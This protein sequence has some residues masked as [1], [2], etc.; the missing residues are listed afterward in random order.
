M[1]DHTDAEL[2]LH[3]SAESD[4]KVSTSVSAEREL[5]HLATGD[6]GK[7]ESA[8]LRRGNRLWVPR[9]PVVASTAELSGRN[10]IRPSK[11]PLESGSSQQKRPKQRRMR[12]SQVLRS[13]SERP[14][15]DE[16]TSGSEFEPDPPV[17]PFRRP[18]RNVKALRISTSRLY[19]S[20]AWEGRIVDERR[21]RQRDGGRGR[22]Y[23]QYL[24]QA[25][26]DR[27]CIYQASLLEEWKRQTRKVGEP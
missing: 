7:D 23:T 26:V 16:S 25:W 10:T 5:L 18:K 11:R 9:P 14:S 22:P 17:G 24:V 21:I 20:R 1:A 4:D 19:E 6:P 8:S 15:D 27:E 13:S 12:F 3:D 2:G